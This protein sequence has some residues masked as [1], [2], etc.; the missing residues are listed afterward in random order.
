MKYTSFHAGRQREDNSVGHPIIA[1]LYDP[2][3]NVVQTKREGRNEHGLYCFTFKTDEQAVT[4]YWRA[5]VRIGGSLFLENRPD[6]KYQTESPQY[7]DQP[8]E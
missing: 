8:A 4:G 2:N 7:R 6:R 1:E 3:G 5:V